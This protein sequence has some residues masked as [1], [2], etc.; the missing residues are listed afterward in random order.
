MTV[1]KIWYEAERGDGGRPRRR[2]DAIVVDAPATGHGLQ[3]LRMPQAA[4]EAFGA[5]PRAARGEAR[6]RA[7]QRSARA[8]RSTSSR[9]RRR[10]RSTR[11]SRPARSSRDDAAHAARAAVR[12]P[13]ARGGASRP[14]TCPRLGAAARARPRCDGGAAAPT[15][16]RARARRAAGRRST[17]A[18]C[19]RLRAE[20]AELPL[21]RA[22]VPLRRG[23]RSRRGAT[24]CR[25]IGRRGR[26]AAPRGDEAASMTLA[27]LV[28]DHRVVICAGSGGVGKTTT[29]ASIALWGA[30]QGRRTV[31]LTIDP[32]RRLADSLGLAALGDEPREI[33]PV[34]RGAG[35]RAARRAG[36]DD[37]RPEGRLGRAGRA[38]RAVAEVRERILANRFYQHLS[39]SFAGSQEYMA[40][41]QLCRARRRA[42]SYDLIVV[43]TPPTRHALDFLEAPRRIADFLDRKVVRWFV[44]PYFSRRL[45]DAAG[46]EPHRRLPLAPARGG[47]RRVGAG[48]DLGLLHR[49]ERPVRRLRRRASTRA[50]SSCAR[51]DGVRA[52]RPSA[53]GAGA[54]RG[55]VPLDEDGRAADAAAG[56]GLQSRAPGVSARGDAGRRRRRG[57]T[58]GRRSGG[59]A[60]ARARSAA[61]PTSRG[62]RRTSSTTSCWRAARRCASSS[63]APACR[64]A[65]RSSRSRTSRATCTTSRAWP[66]MH[67]HLF[68]AAAA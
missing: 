60:G 4:R 67:A 40:I 23:V 50:T 28:R 14:T 53:G 33:P 36:G 47:D 2:W 42:A 46:G 63:S 48:R 8:P 41:E 32:A 49:D 45:G 39:Q 58:G 30:L 44:R 9:R 21:D 64:G 35:P 52:G 61:R 38:P 20:R 51:R 12:E 11:R 55:R 34:L 29:A 24:R 19:D 17:R 13:R 22:A 6:R 66:R 3:Y 65:C 37:A 62:W 57:R 16:R 56:R 26:A 27:E 31:V 15:W 1:G 5:G 59:R 25:R 54:G 7:A 10:C 18:T 68:G 43:D